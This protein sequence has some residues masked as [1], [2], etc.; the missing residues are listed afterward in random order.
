MRGF[1]TP[2][3]IYDFVGKGLPPPPLQSVYSESPGI[4]WKKLPHIIVVHKCMYGFIYGKC[5]ASYGPTCNWI[6]H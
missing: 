4:S 6:R 5:Q 3:Y 1:S 2:N